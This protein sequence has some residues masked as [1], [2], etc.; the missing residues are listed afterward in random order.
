MPCV[1]TLGM[2]EG[3]MKEI[4]SLIGRAVRDADGTDAEA[5]RRAVTALVEAHP[6]YGRAEPARAVSASTATDNPSP[7]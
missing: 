7:S 4:G 5:V 3:D 2:T 6:A 1:V